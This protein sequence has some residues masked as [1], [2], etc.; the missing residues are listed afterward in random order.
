MDLSVVS[1]L[2]IF[3]DFLRKGCGEKDD[4]VPLSENQR[5]LSS[6]D[7]DATS[8]YEEWK[9]E[10]LGSP[11]DM[12]GLPRFGTRDHNHGSAHHHKSGESRSGL[13][14]TDASEGTYNDGN[15]TVSTMGGS[16]PSSQASRATD[17]RQREGVSDND[18]LDRKVDAK[19]TEDIEKSADEGDLEVEF[20]VES[21]TAVLKE[22]T[23][24][25]IGH[26]YK[27]LKVLETEIKVRF[28]RSTDDNSDEPVPKP[29]IVSVYGQCSVKQA[30]SSIIEHCH[31]KRPDLNDILKDKN[32]IHYGMKLVFDGLTMNIDSLD[33]PI[34]NFTAAA[35]DEM[36]EFQICPIPRSEIRQDSS[37]TGPKD[38][39][40]FEVDM[41]G[42]AQ[43]KFGLGS[44]FHAAE[45][46]T[47]AKVRIRREPFDENEP[48]LWNVLAQLQETEENVFIGY[49][50]EFELDPEVTK[51]H[52]WSKPEIFPMDTELTVVRSLG[53]KRLRLVWKG[54]KDDAA[55]FVKAGNTF[56]NML[57]HS[58][59]LSSSTKNSL[60]ATTAARDALNLRKEHFNA[61]YS[62]L[63]G[64]LKQEWN[65]I[66]V[67]QR[68]KEQNRCIGVDLQYI[69]NSKRKDESH[70]SFLNLR[71][72][73]VSRKKRLVKDITKFGF[74]VRGHRGEK[75]RRSEDLSLDLLSMGSDDKSAKNRSL[76]AFW[77]AYG[78]MTVQY[79]ADSPD[80]A[81]QILAKIQ[82]V[83]Q[84]RGEDHDP[85]EDETRSSSSRSFTN[86]SSFLGATSTKKGT[87]PLQTSRK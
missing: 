66:K 3:V 69:Y 22:A 84:N 61:Q 81:A 7:A 55:L 26:L 16:P 68:G 82:W 43:G 27:E 58:A 74:G 8:C 51:K 30:I 46:E 9:E 45:T 17:N 5:L 42:I 65:V 31:K 49:E 73:G 48:T 2:E 24:E 59:K 62:N 54:Y 29:E 18:A 83:R 12:P 6:I 14:D 40:G 85:T 47:T 86:L 78:D 21:P 20:R 56:S 25:K 87:A 52:G 63:S 60:R 34:S 80:E 67:N 19:E 36:Q 28:A 38:E 53:V 70:T 4:W 75:E 64:H 77:I 15:T 37:R 71:I 72:G 11:P 79:F 57:P 10:L 41:R 76:R 44:P 13:S 50:Y 23:K 39:W 32:P 35:G 1:E 33:K